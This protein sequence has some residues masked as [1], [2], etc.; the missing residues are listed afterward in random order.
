VGICGSNRATSKGVFPSAIMRLPAE[1]KFDVTMAQAVRVTPK[2]VHDSTPHDTA[3]RDPVF[4]QAPIPGTE[5][6]T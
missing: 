6:G 4:P 2:D 1:L 3:F 5:S